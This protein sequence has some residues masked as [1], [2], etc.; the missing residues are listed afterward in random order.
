MYEWKYAW[1]AMY[2]YEYINV[3][4]YTCPTSFITYRLTGMKT[5]ITVYW[6]ISGRVDSSWPK[7]QSKLSWWR[8]PYPDGLTNWQ[9]YYV[10]VCLFVCLFYLFVTVFFIFCF[11]FLSLFL[12]IYPFLYSF[13]YFYLFFFSTTQCLPCCVW[14]KTMHMLKGTQSNP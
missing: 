14:S 5:S 2:M 7:V 11:S 1:I 3:C 8:S 9:I 4:I 13:I 10:F 6:A 12:Y